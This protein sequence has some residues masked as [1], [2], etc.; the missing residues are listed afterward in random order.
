MNDPA[1]L[2][3]RAL[4]ARMS[5]ALREG[6]VAAV[7]TGDTKTACAIAR[8]DLGRLAIGSSNNRE[9]DIYSALRIIGTASVASGGMKNG[10]VEE[11][12][13]VS[14]CIRKAMKEASQQAGATVEG[15]IF[16]VTGG[17]PRTLKARAETAI[18]SAEVDDAMVARLMANCRP[19]MAIRL[20]RPLM[21]EPSGFVV[22]NQPGIRDPRGKSAHSLAIDLSILTVER[23][24]LQSLMQA[25]VLSELG[26]DGVV[27]AP[28][29]SALACL[30]EDELELGAVCVDMGGAMTGIAE[31][32][33]RAFQWADT[34]P[35]GG[36]RLSEDIAQA[37]T[38]S[39]TEAE[40][41]KTRADSP[42]SADPSVLGGAGSSQDRSLLVGVVR[43]RLEEIFE[44]VRLKLE[45]RMP[46]PVVLTGGASRLPGVV[47]VA[48]AVLGRRVRLG[49]SIRIPGASHAASGP[50]FS[51]AFGMLAHSVRCEHDPWSEAME[52]ASE[53]EQKFSGVFDWFRRNW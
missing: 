27:C 47:E 6:I 20:R 7:D 31:F 40:E 19:E 10:V 38:I 24:A 17:Q 39:F 37:L 29:A 49:R 3:Q 28:V 48:R 41:M 16:S 36:E 4:R 32:Q 30:T 21:V 12:E 13:L 1:V 2:A 11:P 46:R 34:I 15:A 52:I 33:S 26:V 8:V 43:P 18:P 53:S 51:T 42:V 45:G 9:A 50:E 35:L 22:D 5:A 14:D 44:I 25:A 23:T